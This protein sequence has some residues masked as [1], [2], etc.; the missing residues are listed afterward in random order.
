MDEDSAKREGILDNLDNKYIT[1]R[2]NDGILRLNL[3]LREEYENS[4]LARIR[5][6]QEGKLVY[7]SLH[8]RIR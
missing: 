2:V 8:D 7:N 1:K 4:K 3:K 6:Y 5:A